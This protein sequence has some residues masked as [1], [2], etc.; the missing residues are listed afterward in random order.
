MEGSLYRE[1]KGVLKKVSDGKLPR[2]LDL[3]L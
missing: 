2:K 3:H 1:L